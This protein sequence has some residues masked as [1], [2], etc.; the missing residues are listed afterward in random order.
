MFDFFEGQVADTLSNLWTYSLVS[1]DGQPITIRK[2]VFALLIFSVGVFVAKQISR[3]LTNRLLKK[4]IE[5]ENNR[6]TME[7]LFFY[8]LIAVVLM[9]SMDVGGIP[10]TAFT[11]AGGALAIGLGFGSQNLVKNF[12]SGIILMMERPIKV[13]DFIET[14]SIF[15]Q[16]QRIGFR[17]T[18]VIAY[19]NKHII[20]PNSAFLEKD[21]INWTHQDQLVRA[22]V[23]VGV[24]YGSPTKL[25]KKLLL[26]AAQELPKALDKPK[27][28]V[29]FGDFGDNALAFSL[30]FSI[31]LH[32]LPDRIYAESDMR[33]KIDELFRENGI[34][35][36]FPQRDVHLD[37]LAPFKVELIKET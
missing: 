15:G 33:F 25:V 27:P 29:V 21:V 30:Y 18:R 11:L 14:N 31:A 2:I 16:V 1:I 34:T 9:I 17:S 3:R 13:G 23:S 36:S 6:F 20:A 10:L 22:N 24:A 19:G 7:T 32:E 35:I 4:I 5:D 37:Q 28:T 26:Q 8:V 12:I